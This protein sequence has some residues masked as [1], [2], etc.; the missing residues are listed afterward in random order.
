MRP[1]HGNVFVG[2]LQARLKQGRKRKRGVGCTVDPE[3]PEQ[4]YDCCGGKAEHSQADE[5]RLATP[6]GLVYLHC[7]E[8]SVFDVKG[9]FCAVSAPV[10]LLHAVLTAAERLSARR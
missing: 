9:F 8:Q 5:G 2:L 10:S 1:A 7:G 3:S 6:N 4:N